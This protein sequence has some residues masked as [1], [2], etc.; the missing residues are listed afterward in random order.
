MLIETD[1]EMISLPHFLLIREARVDAKRTFALVLE[2]NNMRNSQYQ[3]DGSGQY[4]KPL[5]PFSDIREK[6]K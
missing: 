1:Y 3:I 4:K 5:S 2:P 6:E